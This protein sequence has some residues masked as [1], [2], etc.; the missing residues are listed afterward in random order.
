[1][2][3]NIEYIS[4]SIHSED[5]D[6]IEKKRL[7]L[8]E[9]VR[10]SI[11][12]VRRLPPF[13]GSVRLRNETLDVFFLYLDAFEKDFAEAIS[14]R[15]KGLDSYEMLEA[16]LDIE[17]RAEEKLSTAIEKMGKAQEKFAEKNNLR[18]TG[19][20]KSKLELQLEK[21]NELSAYSRYIFLRYFYV[22]KSFADLISVLHERD[23]KSLDKKREKVIELS[24]ASIKELK[25]MKPFEGDAEY[26]DQTIDIIE[27]FMNLSRR[28][29]KRIS[30]LF[31]KEGLTQKDADYINQF[32]IDYNA[33]IE[34]L[35]YNWNIA[36]QDLWRN[37][38]EKV[39]M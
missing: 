30:T 23:S 10:E 22:S 32:I 9:S 31:D 2:E 11:R 33:N 3:K 15:K 1:M 19:N 20:K 34:Q 12:K 35:V 39:S 4:F 5:Y 6:L 24:A 14:H 26:R 8:I 25:K 13:E 36:Y 27:Y 29:L 38:V 7:E 37:H 21:I 16:Y 18:I 28:E 17:T